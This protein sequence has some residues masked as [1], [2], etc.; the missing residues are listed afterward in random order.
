MAGPGARAIAE[1]L[2]T[3]TESTPESP[4][5]IE[6][7]FNNR[8]RATKREFATFVQ[9]LAM[10]LRR[11]GATHGLVVTTPD[12]DDTRPAQ[13]TLSATAYLMTRDGFDQWE[14][15]PVLRARDATWDAWRP[16]VPIR[17][18]RFKRPGTPRLLSWPTPAKPSWPDP[19]D[20]P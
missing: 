1:R 9:D 17:A 16:D 4:R 10:L 11:G 20:E 6:L 7:Q 2:A 18:L 13:F 8:S 12:P 15:Y 5:T 19:I 14:L 3:L